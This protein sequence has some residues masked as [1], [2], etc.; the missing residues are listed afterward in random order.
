MDGTLS[1]ADNGMTA[2]GITKSGRKHIFQF[3]F[4]FKHRQSYSHRIDSKNGS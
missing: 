4:T 2:I 1:E 3:E